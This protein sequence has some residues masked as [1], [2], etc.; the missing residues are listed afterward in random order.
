MINLNY[1]QSNYAQSSKTAAFKGL[2]GAMQRDIYGFSE[3]LQALTNVYK[4]NG[5]IVGTLPNEM[6]KALKSNGV[7]PSEMS[8]KIKI[9]TKS[10]AD[11]AQILKEA[12][13][14]ALQYADLF[15]A[16]EYQKKYEELSATG[17]MAGLQSYTRGLYGIRSLSDEQIIP[18][19]NRAQSVIEK[20]F[21]ETALLSQGDKVKIDF[22]ADGTYSNAFKLSFVN[23]N[24]EKVFHD[25]VLKIYKDKNIE[26]VA[27]RKI[28]EK[29]YAY[30]QTISFD[31]FL[32]KSRKSME[33]SFKQT[34]QE[35][36]MSE[37]AF[38][39]AWEDALP[40]LKVTYE[41]LK[42]TT[43]DKHL[44]NLKA[45]L[46]N[47]KNFHGIAPEANR[48][49]FLKKI[50]ENLQYTNYVD[51]HFYDLK[52]S[53]ALTE[54]S[55]DELPAIKRYVNLEKHGLLHQDGE[56]N[57]A[58]TVNGRIVDVGGIGKKGIIEKLQEE[59]A[60]KIEKALEKAFE[61]MDFHSNIFDY[62]TM[63]DALSKIHE[64]LK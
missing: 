1:F 44:N 64:E 17:D 27:I 23:K 51:Q 24:D 54:M 37:S 22:L 45:Q 40:F 21:K 12:E 50:G 34:V 7:Q 5:G 42:N 61:K 25:K 29:S 52:N 46:K 2:Q 41:N 31:E 30:L 43:V 58:N 26:E 63:A 48:A 47:N 8:G 38:E 32:E 18:I 56:L 39:E 6:I 20:A 10:I 4:N 14:V 53:Y 13:I 62:A 59:Q 55:D 16:E 28:V 15:D 11:A 33:N 3:T 9:L 36:D 57:P 19:Q 60:E 35:Y 49:M